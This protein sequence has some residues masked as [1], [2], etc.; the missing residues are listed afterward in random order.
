MV[1]TV[2]THSMSPVLIGTEPWTYENVL[3]E[4][5]M[6]SPHWFST[7]YARLRVL[8]SGP[9]LVMV[10]DTPLLQ[11]FVKLGLPRTATEGA[12]TLALRRE[13]WPAHQELLSLGIGIGCCAPS[14]VLVSQR[15]DHYKPLFW[16]RATAWLLKALRCLGYD[17]MSVYLVNAMDKNG[18]ARVEELQRLE[19][20]FAP[21]QS[22]WVGMGKAARK[23]L[24]KAKI[25]HYSAQHPSYHQKFEA[26]TGHEGYAEHL[27]QQGIL[28]GPWRSE[29]LPTDGQPD[30]RMW[31]ADEVCVPTDL[32]FRKIGTGEG[33]AG[34]PGV[35]KLK[36]EAARRS[37]VLGE[38]TTLKE[39][40][41]LAD[42][43]Y[44]RICEAA[45]AQH[46]D[47]EREDHLK[48]VREKAY[49][50]AADAEGRAVASCRKL[51]WAGAVKAL[52]QVNQSLD[53]G[54]HSPTSGDCARLASLAIQLSDMG[55]A[56]TEA[57]EM[58]LQRMTMQEVAEELGQTLKDQFGAKVFG[59][60]TDEQGD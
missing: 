28:P 37:Y 42:A 34:I 23:V 48:M 33:A 12:D 54:A 18:T 51:A 59:S 43:P 55:A 14:L 24:N 19:D 27:S 22:A 15:D 31:V 60:M 10:A 20:A 6:E 49:R 50:E 7:S 36:S 26:K 39:A 40:A 8:S 11:R 45:R 35:N 4:P 41:H 2:N 3:A 44:E 21:Y 46:W 38:V 30:A 32:A 52:Q 53:A 25:G 5:P 17:E 47:R 16:G 57:E 58:R 29:K 1:P 56:D 13:W 9:A